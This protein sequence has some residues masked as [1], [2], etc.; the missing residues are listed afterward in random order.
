MLPLSGISTGKRST[1]A[2]SHCFEEIGLTDTVDPLGGSYYIETLTNQMEDK[3]VE[4]MDWVDSV[5]GI[6]PAVANGVIQS[7]V[8]RQAYQRQR[9]V[10]SGALRKVGVNCYREEDEEKPQVEMHPYDE[11]AAGQQIESLRRVRAERDPAAVD[12][13]LEKVRAAATSGENVMPA[14][15][16]AVKAYA[17][18]GELTNVLVDV[19]GRFDEPVRL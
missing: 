14:L 18:V 13:S 10:E 6:V 12:A 16:E 3:I 1:T 11:A 9:D 19:Y 4:A 7:H 8:S 5:G 2:A 17:S 15:V